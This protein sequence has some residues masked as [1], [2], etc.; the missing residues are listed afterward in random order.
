MEPDLTQSCRKR[1][2]GA[3]RAAPVKTMSQPPQNG[4]GQPPPDDSHGQPSPN[5]GYGQGQFGGYGQGQAS[6]YGQPGAFGQDASPAPSFGGAGGGFPPQG[7]EKTGPGKVPL[8]ICAGCALLALL[9]VILGGGIF[10]FIRS[11]GGGTDGG[12]TTQSEPA[13]DETSEQPTDAETSEQPTDQETSEQP[14][15]D[16]TSEGATEEAAAGAGTKDD[17]YA[18]GATFT[19]E[20]GEGGTYDVTVGEVDWDATDAVMEANQFNTEPSDGE[21]YIL[22]P[23][24][25]TYHGDSS[26]EVFSAVTVQYA[27]SGGDVYEDLGTTITPHDSLDVESLSD[28]DTGSWEMGMI[29]PEDQVKDGAVVVDTWLN[30]EDEPAWVAV[31]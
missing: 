31:S 1:G 19:L 25:L 13:G 27:T 24:E 10:L 28:G 12:E 8:L 3:A 23:L 16:A 5:G 18:V 26:A 15:D 22:I 17:P 14:A 7:P 21:T 30:A 11:G 20:D 29:V 6:G 4:W 9:L 2:D